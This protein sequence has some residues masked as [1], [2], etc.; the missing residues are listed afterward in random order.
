LTGGISQKA[1]KFKLNH[2]G[3]VVPNILE[4]ID[5]LK[6]LG[7]SEITQP[8]TDPIQKV[9]A[10]FITAGNKQDIYIE[11][12]EPLGD[13]SPITNFLKERGAGL[14]HLCFE[15]DNIEKVGNELIEKGFEMVC[16]PVDCVGYD[17]SFKLKYTQPTKI[18]FF[19]LSNKILIELL[20][21]GK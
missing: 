3:L 21:K 20:Q 15:V 18:A 10:S 8:E 9:A 5:L 19:L 12:I 11:L 4:F 14:H 17:R 16:P 13:N 7:P 6:T 1:M 2:I